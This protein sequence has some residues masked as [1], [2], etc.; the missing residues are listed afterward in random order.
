M[1]PRTERRAE[2]RVAVRTAVKIG[3]EHV[4]PEGI[5]HVVDGHVPEPAALID[6]EPGIEAMRDVWDG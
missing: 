1:V 3:R 6:G 5:A 4:R 2:Q